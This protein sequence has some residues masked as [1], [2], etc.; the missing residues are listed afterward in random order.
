MAKARVAPLKLVMIPR[1]ELTAATMTSRMDT[2]LRKE[3][4]ME[5]ADSIFWTD[6]TSVLEYINNKTTR[7]RTFVSFSEIGKVS[8]A[9]QWRYV[10][11]INNPANMASRSLSVN[12]FLKKQ[13]WVSGPQF[14][15]GPQEKWPQNPDGLDEISPKDC[16]I[17]GTTVNAVQITSEEVDPITRLIHYFSS[18]THLKRAVAGML[19]LKEL[20][21]DH[22]RMKKTKQ[23]FNS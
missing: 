18:W 14:L 19:R 13:I 7:F 8:N 16:E 1:M 3:L 10:N 20:L 23:T 12:S 5:L 15:L 4:Q 22:S 21:L 9:R 6:S 17:R 2:M 11:T